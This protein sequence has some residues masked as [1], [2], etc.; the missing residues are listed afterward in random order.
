MFVMCSYRLFRLF[1][2]AFFGGQLFAAHDFDIRAHYTKHEFRIPMRDGVHLFTAV[3]VPKDTTGKYPILLTRTPYGVEP[4]GADKYPNELG[5]SRKFAEDNFIFA[6]QDVRGRFMSE[7]E[8]VEMGPEKDV[9]HGPNDVDESTDT[10]DT[11]DWLIKNI[12]NNNGKA[13]LL[14][15]SYPGFYTS[16]GL[17]NAHPALV[18]ASPQA[19]ISDLYMGDDAYHNGA[20]FLIANFHFYTSFTK[21]NNPELPRAEK[22]F[23]YGTKDGYKFYLQ[24]GPLNNSNE[25]YFKYKNPYWT[26]IIKHPNYDS[27]WQCRNIL[28]HLN[29][30]R[31]A[32]L[33]VGGWFDAED[34][35]GTLKTYRAI[36]AQSPAT[37]NRLVMGPWA[38]G[39]WA[40]TKG[41][42]LGDISFGS[43]AAKF[44][45]DEIELPFFRYFLKDGP[46][47]ALPQAYVFETGKDV[48]KR[49]PQWPPANTRI[50][51][52]YFHAHGALTAE[53]PSETPAFDEYVS[54][55]DN[56]VPFFSKPTLTMARTYM[57]ADQ[58]FVQARSDVITYQTRPLEKELTV[59]GPISPTLFVS[60]SGTDSDFVV[61]V[62][63]VY[64]REAP[65]VLSGY[66][67]LVRGEPFRGKFRNS[68]EQPEPFKPGETQQIHFTMPDVYHC[69]QTGHRI[70]VQIQSSWFP[71]TDRNP[72]TFTDIRAAKPTQFVKVTNRIYRSSN[73]GSFIAVNVEQ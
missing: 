34:L 64:P 5:P 55:P 27:F 66:E 29:N 39:G 1:L 57:D 61:K 56:P 49:E 35:S 15:I 63:D 44:F 53:P 51:R 48:W 31:P 59:A 38:H 45:Q 43:D 32:V 42:K 13:G 37:S 14:G 50:E 12:S 19:P 62:I 17:I 25:R 54:D 70:M 41:D 9:T 67:Q 68:F 4:Y 73:A 16:A 33:V 22:D 36:R 26:D 8:F 47:P 52:L 6:Y 46:D 28:P 69:F 11:I 40:S 65:G 58:R 23:H 60:T 20:F 7:G 10:Y 2:F 71:L 72:Q 30:I 18:A 21:Q 3:Y 24:M